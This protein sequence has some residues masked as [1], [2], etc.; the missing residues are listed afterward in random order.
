[1]ASATRQVVIR[2]DAGQRIGTGHVM[3]CLSVADRLVVTAARDGVDLRIHFICKAHAGHLGDLIRA[4]GYRCTLLTV[5]PDW[6]AEG[7]LAW[8]G[9]PVDADAALTR[10]AMAGRADL[11]IAD[12]YA[13]DIAW[14]RQLRKAAGSIAAIEDM[15]ARMHHCDILIDQN[16]GH[17][18]SLYADRVRPGTQLLVGADYAPVRGAFVSLRRES[19]ARRASV[20]IPRVLLVSLGGADP[21]DVTSAVLRALRPPLEFDTVHVVLS[22]IAR[23]LDAVREE[24]ARHGNAVLHVDTRQMPE[25]MAE[26]DL[27]IGAAGVTAIERCVLGLPTLMVVVADNQI[28]AAQRMDRL[29][30]VR[31]LGH[32]ADITPEGVHSALAA[33]VQDRPDGLQAMSRAA[34]ALCDGHGLDRIAPALIDIMS[35]LGTTEKE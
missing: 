14:Q 16:I 27:S 18:A 1:M 32:T 34:A 10:E 19:L 23:H 24:V 11:L 3:R 29:G 4:R 33:F 13:I 7:Y 9:G 15:P 26:A 22:G 30:A 35:P 28:E 21:D 12:H 31:L 17:E 5:V 8:L 2:V 20:K 6:K 25:L